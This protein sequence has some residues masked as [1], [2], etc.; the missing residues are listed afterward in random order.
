MA[1]GS[2]KRYRTSVKFRLVFHTMIG[3]RTYHTL[4][5]RS[6][7]ELSRSQ[8]SDRSLAVE[9]ISPLV[10]TWAVRSFLR[11]LFLKKSNIMLAPHIASSYA[12]NA[13][14]YEA[15]NVPYF[16]SSTRPPPARPTVR[17]KAFTYHSYVSRHWGRVQHYYSTPEEN[18]HTTKKH[19]MAEHPWWPR[20][21]RTLIPGTWYTWW[22]HADR[23]HNAGWGYDVNIEVVLYYRPKGCY[24]P[25][26]VYHLL[27]KKEK[28]HGL[29]WGGRRRPFSFRIHTEGHT[30]SIY[31]MPWSAPRAA[32]S[33]SF[34]YVFLST[35]R[36][37]TVLRHPRIPQKYFEVGAYVGQ[38][39]C[40]WKKIPVL[41]LVIHTGWFKQKRS[42][43]RPPRKLHAIA[44][45][46]SHSWCHTDRNEQ[47]KRVTYSRR[48]GLLRA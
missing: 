2:A 27:V 30:Y 44:T 41:V 32:G 25:V 9:C 42:E 29:S 14:T 23:E 38:K 13:H 45:R 6:L 39:C 20:K 12:S 43:L 40:D 19:Q 36:T 26:L 5:T 34:T 37:R 11:I 17:R 15:M 1:R 35:D 18:V 16:P 21:R 47:R 24:F 8:R 46:M 22:Y 10:Y 33:I 7:L 31:Y 3:N 4:P 48:G 28:R